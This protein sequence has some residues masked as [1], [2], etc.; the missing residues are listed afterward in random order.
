MKETIDFIKT[1]PGTNILSGLTIA[2]EIL[3]NEK[4]KKSNES[5][6]S[7]V[8]LLSDGLDMYHNDTQLANALKNMTKGQDLSFTLH[9]LVMVINMM[10]K[11]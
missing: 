10:V 6:V 9:T 3:K 7:S 4:I 8:I 1:N 5:R 2:V 11:L